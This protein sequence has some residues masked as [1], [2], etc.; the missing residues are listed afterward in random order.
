MTL[1][2]SEL[3]TALLAAGFAPELA[4]AAAEARL[5]DKDAATKARIHYAIT[6]AFEA[7]GVQPYL[8]YGAASDIVTR[9][10]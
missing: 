7:R 5:P 10:R 4:S 2:I 6:R 8:A 1:V 3:Y 9:G